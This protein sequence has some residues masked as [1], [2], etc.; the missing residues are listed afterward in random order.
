MDGFELMIKQV[1]EESAQQID[2]IAQQAFPDAVADCAEL[3]FVSMG[4]EPTDRGWSEN[5]ENTKKRE[6]IMGKSHRNVDTG[7]LAEY[8]STP[9]NILDD[10][11]LKNMPHSESYEYANALGRFDDIGRTPDDEEWIKQK[12]VANIVD[13][14]T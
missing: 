13:G 9:G 7:F 10:N 5:S 14:L 4:T 11:W 2:E 12:L 1:V 3:V 8:A 6:G